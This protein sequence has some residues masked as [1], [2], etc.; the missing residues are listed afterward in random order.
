MQVMHEMGFGR[1]VV[2]GTGGTIAGQA[3]SAED[4][5]G[6]RA[7]QVGVADLLR[8]VPAIDRFRER[9]DAEQVAQVD[10]KDMDT[11]VWQRLLARCLHH[12][13]DPAVHGIVV[14]HGTDT[15]EETAWFLHLA[16]GGAGLPDKA[17]VLTGAMRPASS[18][19]PDGPQ[20]LG[21]A[22]VVAD[23]MG[24]GVAVVFAGQVHAA[25]VVYKQHTYSCQTFHSGEAGP[26]AV[27]EEGVLRWLQ[28]PPAGRGGKASEHTWLR[29]WAAAPPVA[30]PRVEIVHSH[31]GASPWLV[32]ALLA[33]S[34]AD[35]PLRGIVVAGTGNG[36][37]HQALEAALERAQAAGITVWRATR[38]ALGTLVGGGDS[39]L[40]AAPVASPAKARI[41]LQWALLRE[42]AGL[43][44][45]AAPGPV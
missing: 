15:M 44:R 35:A 33:G 4:N 34:P 27:V 13:A 28:P 19:A 2:L 14:T 41:A 1:L 6:Y 32:D 45:A 25:A 11:A 39:P 30:W 5:V 18:M 7:A 40:P 12:L 24:A 22:L 16:L 29:Q 8:G 36:S 21:D 9:L 10:S 26:I 31:A 3:A 43:P 38:C 37:V 23:R 20:N 17:V 42:D